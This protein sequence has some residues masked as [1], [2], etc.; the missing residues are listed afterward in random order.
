MGTWNKEMSKR[1]SG[2][3]FLFYFIHTAAGFGAGWFFGHDS[4]RDEGFF[5]GRREGHVM[6]AMDT[7]YGGQNWPGGPEFLQEWHRIEKEYLFRWKNS[8]VVIDDVFD[9]WEVQ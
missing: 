5:E 8:Q 9:V 6:R 7:K 2:P 1:R 3:E 4:G